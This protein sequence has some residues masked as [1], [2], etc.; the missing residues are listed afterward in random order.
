MKVISS[1]TVALTIAISNPVKAVEW[2]TFCGVSM[3]R[4]VNCKVEK[5]DAFLEGRSGMSYTYRLHD[6]DVFQRFIPDRNR[7]RACSQK[8]YMRKNSG[9]WFTIS[10]RC[11]KSGGITYEI[12]QLPSGNSM[13]VERY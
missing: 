12:Y 11:E 4:L 5:G 7:A 8:G 6:G 3:S 2:D 9:R 10:S 1:I 13:L